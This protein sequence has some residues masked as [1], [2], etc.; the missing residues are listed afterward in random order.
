MSTQ[1]IY[2]EPRCDRGCAAV[3][4]LATERGSQVK[5]GPLRGPFGIALDH[6]TSTMLPLSARPVIT[7]FTKA[8]LPTR[9]FLR[10]FVARGA[11]G[12]NE[13]ELHAARTWLAQ[14]DA[15]TIPKNIGELSFSR[16]S[17]P[18][19]QNVNKVNS[20]ATLKVLLN[21]LLRHIPSALH[22]ELRASRYIAPRS[23]A[24]II[25]A[26]DSRKQNDNAH[27]CYMRLHQMVVEAGRN[28]VPG[29]TSPEQAKRVKDL[30]KADN[31]RRIKTK[32]QHSA[33]KTSRRGRGDD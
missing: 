5:W 6:T 31:E 22:P 4:M 12:A 16:S 21:D 19:G 11:S 20:K 23:H 7:P 18:G 28:A 10:R 3:A 27:S 2:E 9:A 26:D 15:E 17:G 32:K 8:Q 30:Q 1:V 14:L 13:E 24:I 25:Q 33:K 29:E